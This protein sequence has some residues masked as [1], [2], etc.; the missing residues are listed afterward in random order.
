MLIKIIKLVSVYAIKKEK[1]EVIL[2]S[3]VCFMSLVWCFSALGETSCKEAC[4]AFD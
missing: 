3:L 1:L 2:I 4:A